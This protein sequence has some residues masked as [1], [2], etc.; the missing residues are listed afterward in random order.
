MK[1]SDFLTP[2]HVML[3]IRGSEKTR[4][5]HQLSTQAAAEAG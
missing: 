2:S 5:L 4:L 1:I 3:D